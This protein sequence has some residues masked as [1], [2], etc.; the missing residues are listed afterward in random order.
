ML[1]A[2]LDILCSRMFRARL[3]DPN[4]AD[5]CRF[6]GLAKRKMLMTAT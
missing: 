6:F 1:N 2:K 3:A 5:I 4:K